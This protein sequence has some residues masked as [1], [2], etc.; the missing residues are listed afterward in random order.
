M[1]LAL[2]R[3][4]AEAAKIAEMQ[5]DEPDLMFV[6]DLARSRNIQQAQFIMF[7]DIALREII[8]EYDQ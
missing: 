6:G 2:A 5:L 8:G 7:I 3:K 4:I 1:L